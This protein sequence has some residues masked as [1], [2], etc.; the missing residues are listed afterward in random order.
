M[1]VG[2]SN[3]HERYV[4]ETFQAELLVCLYIVVSVDHIVAVYNEDTSGH[5][6]KTYIGPS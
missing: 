5:K 2:M 1:Q 3:S 4:Q 6:C